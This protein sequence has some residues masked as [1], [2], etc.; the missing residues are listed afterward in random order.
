[1]LDRD[2]TTGEGETIGADGAS[3]EFVEAESRQRPDI[4][5]ILT[6]RIDIA[7]FAEMAAIREAAEILK[8]DRRMR[9]AR[10]EVHSGALPAA[11][12]YYK[13]N[14]TPDLIVVEAPADETR[15]FE[16]LTALA[17][18][19][20]QS[21]KVI[22]VGQRNDITLYRSL[23]DFGVGEY[24]ACPVDSLSLLSAIGRLYR[25]EASQAL[26]KVFAFFGARGGVGSSTLAHN[27][28]WSLATDHRKDVLLIDLDLSFGTSGLD[29]NLSPPAGIADALIEASKL[30]EARLERMVAKKGE[31]LGILAPP[32]AMDTD[33]DL[34]GDNLEKLIRT[35][36]KASQITVLDLPHTWAPWMRELLLESDEIVVTA[37][38]DLANMR[39]FKKIADYLKTS[40]PNDR[41]TRLVLNQIGLPKRP[42]IKPVDFAKATGAKPEMEIAY[43]GVLFGRAANNGQM[44]SETG[45]T[46][47][48]ARTIGAFADRLASGD[49]VPSRKA[50]G[51]PLARL[52]KR[53]G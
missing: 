1:M 10:L 14:R 22:V 15:L 17:E 26:G 2:R 31:R 45:K 13:A 21:T 6:P 40:R 41:P 9:R 39:N 52:F 50:G 49:A 48:C 44:L 53:A 19:C 33:L 38:P 51:S 30:D 35:A 18:E 7:V 47:Q 25:S 27:T 16:W 23:I 43:D 5:P 4:E 29:F 12:T 34:G 24:L 36:R 46:V 28:A 42:E 20:L 8:A 37:V 3:G 11:I 32:L